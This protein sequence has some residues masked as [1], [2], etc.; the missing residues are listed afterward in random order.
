MSKQKSLILLKMLMGILNFAILTFLAV[1]ILYTIG[2]VRATYTARSF[3]NHITYLPM[4][5]VKTVIV[6][7]VALFTLVAI[8]N[9]RQQSENSILNQTIYI[10]EVILCGIIICCVY[11]EY[12]GIIFLVIADIVVLIRDK[13]SQ[14]VFLVIMGL[15]YIFAD[16]DIISLGIKMVSFQELLNV[17]TVRHHMLMTGILNFLSSVNAIAFIAYM[18]IYMRSQIKEKERVTI[19]NQQL[20]EANAQLSE[21]NNQLKDYAAMQKQMGEIEERNRIA[22]EIHDTLGHTMT[23]LSA[24]IDA[25]IAL[26]DYSADETK[27]QLNIISGVARQG[28]KDVRRSMKKLRPDTLEREALESAIGKLITETMSTSKVS[29]EFQSFLP[30]LVFEDDEEDTIYRIVQEGITNA[31]RHGHAS[32]I[33]INFK[34]V[35]IWLVIR[36]R[37]NGIGCKDIHKGFGLTHMKERVDMLHGTVT[38][39]SNNGFQV[40]A[41]LPIIILGLKEEISVVGGVGDGTEV[42]EF[43]AKEKPDI[44][45]MDIRMPTMDGVE[46][47]KIVKEKYPEIKIIVLTTFDD[48]KYVFSALKYGASGYLLKGISVDELEKAIHVVYSGGAM[49]NPEIASKVVEL[50]SEMAQQNYD[51]MIEA[52]NVEKINDMEWDI[53]KDVGH[54]MSNKEIA[55]HIGLTEG[56]VRNYISTILKKIGLRDRTQLAIWE[57]QSGAQKRRG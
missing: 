53:I 15:I 29:I 55:D 12:K 38:Y 39:S 6:M 20:A 32:R 1:I 22:R 8:I 52:E 13:T 4:N 24:G 41:K 17:Y 56:T 43:I 19:L 30:S 5:P 21:M 44:I 33:F 34:K 47:T 36:I 18:I 14:K 45:L 48:D 9:L 11:M 27:K 46:C 50:F 57:V 51:V 31:I 37:D 49:I 23:G 26:I 10:L 2:M 16:Y 3:L 35:D 28:L 42:L 7:Y 40:V 54:G 25:C